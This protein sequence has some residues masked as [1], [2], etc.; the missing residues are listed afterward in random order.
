MK[1][2]QYWQRDRQKAH[3]DRIIYNQTHMYIDKLILA[4]VK[5]ILTKAIQQRKD[6]L[7]NNCWKNIGEPY[8]IKWNFNQCFAPYVIIKLQITDLNIKPKTIKV[9]EES[10]RKNDF[11]LWL[12]YFSE[13]ARKA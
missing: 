13:M 11:D 7:F 8:T 2:V 10:I 4:F 6:S 5:L 3:W 1:T 12:V 9:L